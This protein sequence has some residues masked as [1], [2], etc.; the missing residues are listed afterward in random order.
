MLPEALWEQLDPKQR[1]A[2][3]VHELAHIRRADHGGAVI[4]LLVTGLFW[5]HPVVWWARHEL[6]EAE[7]QCCDAWVVRALPKYS[8]AYATALLDTIDFLSDACTPTQVWRADSGK[9]P[10][11]N[12]E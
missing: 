1:D 7:E 12:G 3:L 5:W 2:L 8:K 9:C 6:R 4:E 10:A 11:S